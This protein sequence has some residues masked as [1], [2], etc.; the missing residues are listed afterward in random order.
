MNTL[1]HKKETRGHFD[2][3]W[4]NTYHTFSFARYY[5]PQRVNFGALRVL[6]DD[7]IKPGEGFGRHPHDNMEIITIPIT[8]SVL[9][10]D[11]MGHEEVIKAGEIQVMSAGTGIFHEEYNASE[12]EDTSL[13]QIWIFPKEKNIKPV[14]NQTSFEK[15][16]AKNSWQKLVTQNDPETLHIHQDAVISRTFLDAGKELTYNL[17]DTSFGSYLFVIDGE[18]EVNGQGLGKRD[19]LGVSGTESFTVKA[20]KDSYVLNLEIP[21]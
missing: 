19:G 14:Y 21:E 3:G 6:N 15:E 9:H 10:R 2:Y 18:V 1:L 16:P 11:S 5:D 13:L 7:I 17:Q 12:S 4:L 20:L 8:G